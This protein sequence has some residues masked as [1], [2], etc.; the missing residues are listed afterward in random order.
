MGVM[1]SQITSLTF[2]YPTVCSG[3]NKINHQSSVLLASDQENVS[4]WWRDHDMIIFVQNA[5]QNTPYLAH[6]SDLYL[7]FVKSY[8]IL[9]SHEPC[10]RRVHCKK[11]ML[12]KHIN[13]IKGDP[14]I[15][16]TFTLW[17]HLINVNIAQTWFCDI[18]VCYL[19]QMTTLAPAANKKS[20]RKYPINICICSFLFMYLYMV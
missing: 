5:N 17:T 14:D 6:E 4:S 8:V 10:S 1:A 16:H 9:Y 15:Y 2:I 3:A 12:N 20:L 18:A 11:K 19:Q 7:I 13:S